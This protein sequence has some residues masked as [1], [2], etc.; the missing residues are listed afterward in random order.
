MMSIPLRLAVGVAIFAAVSILTCVRGL[1]RQAGPRPVQ[2]AGD[3]VTEPASSDWLP[4]SPPGPV[5]AITTAS[6]RPES[7]PSAGITSVL[8]TTHGRLVIDGYFAR[9]IGLTAALGS[10]QLPGKTVMHSPNDYLIAAFA[11]VLPGHDQLQQISRGEN[12]LR[13]DQLL[14]KAWGQQQFPDVSGVCR[15]LRALDWSQ[16]EAIREQLREVF[17]PYVA[18]SV[19]PLLARH[20][21]LQVDWDLTAKPITTDA[22]SD[23]FA[24]Y[25]HME[26]E[27]ELGKGYQ[28]AETVVRGV[29]PDSQPRPVAIGGFLSP[30]NTHPI[31]C[32]ERLQAI[33][34][35]ALG[36]PR[37]RPDLL[38]VHIADA[39]AQERERQ[40]R[41]DTLGSLVDKQ[42]ALI[43]KLRAQLQSI[44]DRQATRSAKQHVLRAR[45][46]AGLAAVRRR[47]EKA[48]HRLAERQKRL[49][50]GVQALTTAQ[51]ETETLRKRLSKL[52]AENA[53]LATTNHSGVRIET[54]MDCQFGDSDRIAG[55]L[56]DG[57]DLTTKARSPATMTKLLGREARGEKVFGEWKAVSA[58]AAVAECVQTHYANCPHPLRLLG[59]RKDLAASGSKPARTTYGLFLTSLPATERTSQEVVNQYHRRGGTAELLNRE[60][61]SDLGWRGQRL[62]YGP[63]LDVLGQFT[64]AALN[65]VPWL[66]DTVWHDSGP[67][68]GKRP[69]LAGLTRL[70]RAPA[71]VLADEDAVAVQF[72][73]QAGFPKRTLTLHAL[74]QPPLPGFAWPGLPNNAQLPLPN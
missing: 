31:A 3:P 12:P 41:V 18:L 24:A 15:Q 61:K 71:Q 60:A 20:E 17:A 4:V 13:P 53:G 26:S 8:S 35:R 44:E 39:E 47:L 46:E 30:G 22:K 64:F 19:G 37:R 6:T 72:S 33:T 67:E 57:Y 55:L 23:P 70:A 40:S 66:A 45:D 50:V 10:L 32:M 54:F 56:E 36:R 49:A 34:E 68:A 21:R 38:G 52:E 43:D 11:N 28:W 62:R 59:Y 5:A 74:R 16:T 69:G 63:G 48:D 1:S 9:R 58:N 7:P 27:G 2:S 42:Q 73:D 65:F 29:G 51:Q 14:A 25:G